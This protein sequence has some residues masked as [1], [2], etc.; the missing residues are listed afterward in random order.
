MH[1]ILSF[2]ISLVP[3]HPH[4]SIFLCISWQWHFWRVQVSYFVDCPSVWVCCFHLVPNKVEHCWSLLPSRKSCSW[5]SLIPFLYDFSLSSLKF[6]SKSSFSLLWASP[7][8]LSWIFF[9]SPFSA[10]DSQISKPRLLLR[11]KSTYP[12]A[13]LNS[14]FHHLQSTCSYLS[15][16]CLSELA[17][18][19][20]KTRN[21]FSSFVSV[22][23]THQ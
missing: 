7:R 1:C 23:H 17:H 18:L 5:V 20:A 8:V 10:D 15:V 16:S 13:I 22:S 2:L 21:C 4:F 11:F 19:V 14:I 3:F 12:P 9:S 6:P